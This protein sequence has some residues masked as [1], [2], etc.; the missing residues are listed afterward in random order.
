MALDKIAFLPFGYLMDQWRWKVFD[1][2]IPSTD[3]NKEWWNLRLKYQG[4]CPPVTRTEDDFDPGAKF[5]IPA[6]VPYVRYFVSFVI[7]FQFHKALCDA[8][9]H[10]G[11]LH[12]CDIY[13]SKEAGKLLGDVMK[14]GYSKPWP[15]AMAMI[16]GQ[17]KMTAQP[18][19]QYF[20]PLIKWLEEENNKNSEVRGW[21]DYNWKPLASE[22]E[23]NDGKVEFLGLKVDQAAAKAGQWLL[24]SISLAFLLVIM[25]LAYRYRKSKNRDKSLSMLELKQKD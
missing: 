16:T 21:P 4:L 5:H 20:E 1:G 24:L 17:S 12:T 22:A 2:R 14:L 25:L 13:Q 6:N 15:E 11:P 23:T 19:M 8:A 3:Y 7:Q 9:N 10:V 18:L